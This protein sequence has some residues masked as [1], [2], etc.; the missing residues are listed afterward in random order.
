MP[1]LE[2]GSYQPCSIGY[3]DAGGERAAM[4]FYG[5]VLTAANFDDQVAAWADVLTAADALAAGNRIVDSYNDESR[6]SVARPTN[7][8]AREVGLQVIFRD[9]TTGQTFLATLPTV[10]ISLITYDP[11]YGAKDVVLLTSTEVAAFISALNA[12]PV[13]NPQHQTNTVTVVGMKVIRGGK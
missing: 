6:Y 4:H 1:V 11:N 2:A 13:V 10:D 7:G 12:F 5:K 9:G 3:L 8:A